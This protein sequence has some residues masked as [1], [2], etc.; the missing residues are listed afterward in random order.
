MYMDRRVLALLVVFP[1]LAGLASAQGLGDAA[2][3]ERQKRHEERGKQPRVYDNQDLDEG[4]PA[5]KPGTSTE[6]AASATPPA[7]APE[8]DDRRAI[9]ADH[10]RVVEAEA[11]LKAAEDNLA[12]LQSR[13]KAAEDKLNPMSPSF[14]Y[15]AAASIDAAGEEMRTKEELQKIEA[16]LPEAQKAVDQARKA[17]DDARSGRVTGAR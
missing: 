4:K 14:I 6:E 7:E 2:A 15:G 13:K 5:K 3:K 11:Q 9:D 10:A 8:D 12:A 16:E 17:L 1:L